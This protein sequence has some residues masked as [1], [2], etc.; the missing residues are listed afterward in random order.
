MKL[1]NNPYRSSKI[2]LPYI[3]VYDYFTDDE[4]D[5]IEFL[6]KTKPL[7]KAT[8]VST[9]D[10]SIVDD[11]P[12]RISSNSFH[13]IQEENE[14]FFEKLN[15][16]IESINNSV[17]GFELYGYKD[18]QYAEYEGSVA[19]KYGVHM[20]LIMTDAKPANL[21]DTRKLSMTLLLSEPGKDFFGGD[22]LIHE[23]G[24]PTRIPMKRGSLVFFPSF[25]LHEVTP[26]TEGLR[27]SIVVWVEG[28][29]FR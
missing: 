6:S 27:K 28:P 9:L 20:D 5:Q 24:S 8:T 26:V 23:G 29:K 11:N 14:W 1:S 4:L 19:G 16:A 13:A 12:L 18:Y 10:G 17:Y 22:F 21:L 25:M 15:L 7:N 3:C 2:T